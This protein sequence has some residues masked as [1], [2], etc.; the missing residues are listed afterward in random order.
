MNALKELPKPKKAIKKDLIWF[1]EQSGGI[2]IHN[3][4][5]HADAEAF[6]KKVRE[7]TPIEVSV[8]ISY[9]VVRIKLE[10]DEE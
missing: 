1:L 10:K 4:D 5:V 9:K 6:G 3:F 7:T 8:D 2:S